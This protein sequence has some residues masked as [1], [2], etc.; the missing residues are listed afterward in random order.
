MRALPC[1]LESGKAE[2]I[3][4]VGERNVAALIAFSDT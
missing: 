3:R 4:V 1:V 2:E